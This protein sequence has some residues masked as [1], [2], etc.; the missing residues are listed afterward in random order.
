M[1]IH[2][3]QSIVIIVLVRTIITAT[4]IIMVVIVITEVIISLSSKLALARARAAYVE[5]GSGHQKSAI[6]L[7]KLSNPPP[8][9]GNQT[10]GKEI[11]GGK[12]HR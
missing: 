5:K 2:N 6:R 3:V 11:D 1:T 7:I 12:M 9:C 4:T 10:T 8:D